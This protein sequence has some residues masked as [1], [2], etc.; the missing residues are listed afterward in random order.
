MRTATVTTVLEAPKAD[1]FAY[2]SKIENLP[3]WATEFAR[4]LRRDGDTYRVV[5]GL[6]EFLFDIRADETTGV[7]DMFAGPSPDQMAVF[8]T[9][10]VELAR[11][12]HRVHVHD[13]PGPGHAGR[14]VR[15]AARVAATR[16]REHRAGLR[17]AITSRARSHRATGGLGDGGIRAGNRDRDDGRGW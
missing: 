15:V 12:A 11:R 13:V 9:R 4:E 8:P 2:L 5:N 17:G 1:V 7:I 3:D 14:A 10:A 6:G 16:V